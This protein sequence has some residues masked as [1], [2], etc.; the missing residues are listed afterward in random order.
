MDTNLRKHFI[1]IENEED[2]KIYISHDKAYIR[3]QN[4]KHEKRKY[5]LAKELKR[6]KY[7]Y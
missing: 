6:N 5:K 1:N 2:K 4:K 3:K 7:E